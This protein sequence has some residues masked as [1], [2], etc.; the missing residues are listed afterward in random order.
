LPL[1]NNIVLFSGRLSY[2]LLQKS[3]M[4]GIPI[5]CAIGAPSSLAIEMAEDNGITLIGFLKNDSFNIYCGAE[6]IIQS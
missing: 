5:V 1:C 3:L 2:E 6:R 4:A